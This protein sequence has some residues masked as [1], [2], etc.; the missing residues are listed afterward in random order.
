VQ[1]H[2]VTLLQPHAELKPNIKTLWECRCPH[3]VYVYD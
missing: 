2:D 3:A 1:P